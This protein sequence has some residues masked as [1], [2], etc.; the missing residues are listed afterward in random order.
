MRPPRPPLVGGSD[1]VG[2]WE[3]RGMPAPSKKAPKDQGS[4]QSYGL[5]YYE[6]V[7]ASALSRRFYAGSFRQ[8]E[9]TFA[10]QTFANGHLIIKSPMNRQEGPAG[11]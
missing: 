10:D 5:D 3:Y 4:L 7:I 11:P 1:R 2:S 9:L 8:V 6:D